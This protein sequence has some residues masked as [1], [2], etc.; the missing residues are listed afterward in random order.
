M[1]AIFVVS[2]NL[3]DLIKQSYVGDIVNEEILATIQ[4]NQN[5]N[6]YVCHEGL[7]KRKKK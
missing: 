7:L 6:S 4:Q 3:H 1:L 5:V 2:S